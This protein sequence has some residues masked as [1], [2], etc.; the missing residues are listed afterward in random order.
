M[1]LGDDWEKHQEAYYGAG[2]TESLWLK[3]KKGNEVQANLKIHLKR[4]RL[5]EGK[6][7]V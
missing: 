4:R 7:F 2:Q 5:A 1:S 3:M 6:E